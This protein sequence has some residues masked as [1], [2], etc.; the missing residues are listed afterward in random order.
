MKRDLY[1]KGICSVLF[2]VHKWN[3]RDWVKINGKRKGRH[4]FHDTKP[5]RTHLK[6]EGRLMLQLCNQ[7]THGTRLPNEDCSSQNCERR[8]GYSE[9]S[10]QIS[11]LSQTQNLSTMFW[12]MCIHSSPIDSQIYIPIS[13]ST[14]LEKVKVQA[15]L[16]SG[17]KTLF[18]SP[19]IIW[20][21]QL[22]TQKLPSSIRL[23]NIDQTPNIMG[24]IIHFLVL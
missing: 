5:R 19:Q 7:R 23:Q 21:Y 20:K 10:Q 2:D 6:I 8:E 14:G 3:G 15:M 18:I 9:Q 16:D 17:A 11:T 13:L 22:T 12:I 1:N 4:H 24:S